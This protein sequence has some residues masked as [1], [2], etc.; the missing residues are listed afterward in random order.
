LTTTLKKEGL[1]P[2]AEEPCLYHNDWLIVFFYVDD[3]TA[4]YRKRD[5]LKLKTFKEHLIRRYEI[6]D[7][8]ELT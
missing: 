8:G 7:L 5:L 6:K 4:A 3:I 1:K 2:V